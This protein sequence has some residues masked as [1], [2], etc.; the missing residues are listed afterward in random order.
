M[1]TIKLIV[2]TV[3]IVMALKV[4]LSEGMIFQKVGEWLENKVKDGHKIYD[5]F[6]CPYCMNSLQVFTAHAFAF[7]L[8]IIP[9]EF[10]W[11]LLIRIPLVVFA[12]SFISGNLWNLY[13]T[14]NRIKEK[15]EAEANYYDSLIEY[16]EE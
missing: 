1:I 12:S 9:F 10:S 8:N 4:A 5:L 3:T 15:N 16:K 11:P 6:I 14:V 7:G 2:I 13:E